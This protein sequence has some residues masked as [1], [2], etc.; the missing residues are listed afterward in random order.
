MTAREVFLVDGRVQD[1]KPGHAAFPV[2]QAQREFE[3]TFRAIGKKYGW[4]NSHAALL[5][6]FATV[7]I[8]EGN[9]LPGAIEMLRKAAADLIALTSEG[10]C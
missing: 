8:N 10:S 2:M 1:V 6:L 7:A 5:S 4:A 3:K 9:S